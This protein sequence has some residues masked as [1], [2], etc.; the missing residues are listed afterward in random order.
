MIKNDEILST[1]KNCFLC[2][3]EDL[4]LLISFPKTP[5]ANHLIPAPNKHPESKLYPLDLGI[6]NECGHIQLLTII[7]STLLF[8]NYPYISVTNPEASNRLISLSTELNDIFLEEYEETRLA[9]IRN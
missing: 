4:Q 3:S 1:K 2:E 9:S 5:I 7:S 8:Q 6:C